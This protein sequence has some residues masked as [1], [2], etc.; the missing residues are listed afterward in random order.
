MFWI[1]LFAANFVNLYFYLVLSATFEHKYKKKRGYDMQS[2]DD[3]A[4]IYT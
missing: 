1:Y 3:N 2:E 4:Y